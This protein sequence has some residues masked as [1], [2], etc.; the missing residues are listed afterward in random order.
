MKWLAIAM[1]ILT[2]Q[3]TQSPKHPRASAQ[4]TSQEEATNSKQQSRTAPPTADAANRSESSRDEDLRIQRKLAWFTGLL[5]LVGFLQAGVMTLQWLVYRRQSQIMADQ[6]TE[7]HSQWQ[8]MQGQLEQ[9]RS[10]GQQTDRMIEQVTKQVSHLETSANAAKDSANAARESVEVFRKKDR[11]RLRVVL[12]DLKYTTN[13]FEHPVV[14]TVY[15]YGTREAFIQG[16]GIALYVTNSKTRDQ[17]Y[18]LHVPMYGLPDVIEPKS[19]PLEIKPFFLRPFTTE[20]IAKVR[21]KEM[22]VHCDGYIGY[23]DVFDKEWEILVRKVWQRSDYGV[24]QDSGYW[25]AAGEE[26]ETEDRDANSGTT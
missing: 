14:L 15:I 20:E 1:L 10:S 5:V 19:T 2:Q 23:T 7:M 26:G 22:F 21:A 8:A 16:S 12:K 6:R 3:P 4:T 24:G 18:R 9:M 17:G 13:V 25:I 11:A